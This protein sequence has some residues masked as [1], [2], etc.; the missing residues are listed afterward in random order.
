[1]KISRFVALLAVIALSSNLLPL[2]SF[3]QEEAAPAAAA[4]EE[5]KAEAPPAEEKAAEPPAAEEKPAAEPAEKPAEEAPAE[6][7]KPAAEKEEK[8]AEPAKE[9][10]AK[11]KPAKEEAAPDLLKAQ[12]ILEDLNNPCGVAIQPETGTIFV[13]DSGNHQIVKIEDGK[14]VAVITDFP[15]DVYGKGPKVNI[16]PL[17]MHFLDKNTL[18]VGG[19]GMPDG[20]ELLRAYKLPE[21]GSAIKAD[22]MSVSFKLAE[23]DE[24]KGEGNF[25]AL[26]SNGEAIFVSCNGDDTKGWV[27]RAA[28]KDG[29]IADYE[30]YLAT[31]EA[32]DVDAPVGMTFSPEG[33]LVVGQ[34]G[35]INVPGDS[36]ITFYDAASKKMLL[37]IPTGLHDISGI[38]YSGRGQMYVID[39]AWADSTQGGLFQV[40]ED[41]STES[42]IR[43]KK[44]LS[45]DKPTAMAFDSDG[46]LLITVIGEA[47]EEANSKGQLIRV[48]ANAEL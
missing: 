35:E 43:T 25:Y 1:M 4:A 5:T 21:D 29:T 22:A 31:K 28:I 10:A 2:T 15:K 24:V 33:Y 17:G 18:I 44:L 14:A 36:L 38:A 45:L 26:A 42:K 48:P 46:S 20:E 40:L 27:A 12:V 6:E 11:E 34:M 23:T 32:T 3:A 16:G 9:E 8:A 37:N 30:R 47:D 39:Y 7:E 13:A 19:G 41:E